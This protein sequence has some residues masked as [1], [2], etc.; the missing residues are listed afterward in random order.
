MHVISHR[1]DD[2]NRGQSRRCNGTAC[3]EIVPRAGLVLLA[4]SCTQRRYRARWLPSIRTSQRSRSE[5]ANSSR[6]TA[7]ATTASRRKRAS[8]SARARGNKRARKRLILVASL[9]GA[10]H[11]S[12]WRRRRAGHVRH[13]G[14]ARC[15]GPK[16]DAAA[17][18]RGVEAHRGE[19]DTQRPLCPYPQVARY[20]G[21]GSIDE[22]ANFASVAQ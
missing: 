6:I 7:G 20:K 17:A 14:P 18:D 15:M 4:V 22:A 10:G 1:P 19:G 12:L 3:P 21:T 5:A 11:G 2:N 8:T 9:H 16:R 13:D